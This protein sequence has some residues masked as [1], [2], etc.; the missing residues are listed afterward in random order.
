MQT[1]SVDIREIVRTVFNAEHIFPH[2]SFSILISQLVKYNGKLSEMISDIV[3]SEDS[4]FITN[5]EITTLQFECEG[6]LIK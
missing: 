4:K 2:T 5:D 6:L 3:D 1:E